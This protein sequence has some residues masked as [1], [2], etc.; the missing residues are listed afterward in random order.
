VAFR[1]LNL[2]HRLIPRGRILSSRVFAPPAGTFHAPTSIS[3][4]SPPVKL[5]TFSVQGASAAITPNRVRSQRHGAY[6]DAYPESGAHLKPG[7]RSKPDIV[8]VLSMATASAI[9]EPAIRWFR[10][11]P[12]ATSTSPEESTAAPGGWPQSAASG[13][14]DFR[15]HQSGAGQLDY[16]REL[17]LPRVS[18][19]RA[20]CSFTGSEIPGRVAVGSAV[21]IW[22]V[23]CPGDLAATVL[24]GRGGGGRLA[25]FV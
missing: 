12:I 17:G 10:P 7:G 11:A 19:G 25:L 2:D 21:E 1:L 23:D 8:A 6:P 5:Q 13:L 18:S 15:S 20:H 14:G 22:D 9:L 3:P 24:S 16:Y 4:P